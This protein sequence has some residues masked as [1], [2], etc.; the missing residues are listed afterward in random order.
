MLLLSLLCQYTLGAHIHKRAEIL[1]NAN[2]ETNNSLIARK[3]NTTRSVIRKWRERA[4][5]LTQSE[6]S[7]EL[8]LKET[9]RFLIRILS[10]APRSGRA[11]VY[12]EKC[13]CK[14]MALAV[15]NPEEFGRAVSHWS[16]SELTS[17]INQQGIAKGISRSSVGR[18]LQEADIRP[19]KMRY[20]LTPKIEDEE[21]F[22]K[23]VD[24][25]CEVYSHHSK[26]VDTTVYS[27]DEKTGIQALEF[28]N[29]SKPVR[30]GSPE[31]IEFEYKRH[32]TLCLIPSF[33]VSTGKIDTFKIGETR[34]E[35][36]FK[37]HIQ[38]SVD[39]S[40]T[41]KI[42]FVADQLNTHKS[43]SLVRLIIKECD[44]NITK[45]TMGV[46][47]DSGILKSQITRMNFLQNPEHRIRFCYTPKHCSWLNQVE[48]WFGVLSR[49]LLKRGSFSSLSILERKIRDFIEYFNTHLA[50]PYRWTYEGKALKK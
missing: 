11:L 34:N 25:I 41:S 44:L 19:H 28:I 30:V 47:G 8:D 2:K 16:L 9:T 38:H 15:R 13:C 5:Y 37:E 35:H 12:D 20:W 29:P 4:K 31:K 24:Q 18:I 1:L 32:G 36:D 21:L 45:E 10:D 26:Q 17:E 42:I 40:P 48:I 22:E 7:E 3:L 43:E 27:V 33:N 14:I 39:Q 49:K 23:Q 46:K 50:K 6:W